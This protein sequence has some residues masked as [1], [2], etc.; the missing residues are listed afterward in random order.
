[1]PTYGYECVR[2]KERFEVLQRISDPPMVEHEGCGGELR[3]LLYP[4]GIVFKGSGF[5][6][7]DYGPTGRNGVGKSEA[8]ADSGQDGTAA[9]PTAEGKGDAK[10]AKVEPS[11]SSKPASTD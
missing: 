3:R 6:V 10:P 1:M 9:K 4:I 7:N 5:H 2:C 8:K 11:A